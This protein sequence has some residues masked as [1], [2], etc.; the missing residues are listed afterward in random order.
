[1]CATGSSQTGRFAAFLSKNRRYFAQEPAQA[2][3]EADQAL[4][5]AMTR[6]L[7]AAMPHLQRP[8]CRRFSSRHRELW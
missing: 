4:S 7:E 2:G 6:V 3:H 5:N 1:L 8:A